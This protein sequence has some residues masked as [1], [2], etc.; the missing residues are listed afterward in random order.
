M[1]TGQIGALRQLRAL[2]ASGTATGLTDRELLE[3]YTAKRTESLE[4]ATAAEMAFAALVDRHG[5]MV[6]GVCHRVLGDPHEA[7]DAFQA[8]FLVLIRKARSVRVDGSLGRWLYGVAHR[9]ALRSRSDAEQR[10]SAIGGV[11]P[12][13]SDDPASVAELRELRT[14]VGEEVDGLPMKYRCAVELCHLQGMTYDQAAQQLNWPVATVKNRL[15]KGRLRLRARLA[16]RGLAPGAVTVAV[17]TALTSAVVPPTLV[18]STLCAATAGAAGAF[19][20]AVIKLAN[21]VL[22]IMMLEKLRLAS[23]G[24]VVAAGLSAHALWQ[25]T[26]NGRSQATRPPQT[27]ARR[28]E[29]PNENETRDRRWTRSLPSGATIDVIGVSSL[30]DG[31]DTWWRPDG[32]PFQPAPL[33]PTKQRIEDNNVI[34]RLIIVRVSGIPQGADHQ[35]SI[36][37][38]IVV[39]RGP[40]KSNFKLETD[41]Y[42]ITVSHPA[43]ARTCTVRFKVATGPWNTIHTA[44]KYAGGGGTQLGWSY[45][46]GDA[47]ATANGTSLSVTHNIQ[48]QSVRL[49]AVDDEGTESA[50]SVES[51]IDVTDFRQIKF[52]FDQPPAQ[53]KEFRL[54]VRPYEEV[55]IPGIA[56]ERE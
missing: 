56:L 19:K 10:R 16:R 20:T 50:G 23:L 30:P 47:I 28:L 33:A 8:T 9:I 53:L 32:T 1:G 34:Q 2:F 12:P 54:E 46:C 40:F 13:S 55:E 36:T 7:E 31:P 27:A 6:W 14:V 3:R 41:L 5:A 38:A 52:D 37:D 49:V 48:N 25:Q 11:A 35:S 15:T 44:G 42:E 24:V 17:T 4:A 26:A 29:E 51:T 21:W 18:Q 39:S 43:D 45:I 22:K